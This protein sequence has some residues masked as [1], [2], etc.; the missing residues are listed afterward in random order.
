MEA[1][2]ETDTQKSELLAKLDGAVERAK[3]VCERMQEQTVAAAKATDRAVREHPYPAL[4]VAF[5]LGILIGVLAV[6]ARRD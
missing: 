5:G 1:T 4:G 6:R 2:K 3:R